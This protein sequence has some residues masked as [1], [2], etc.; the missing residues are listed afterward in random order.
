MDIRNHRKR[1]R[2]EFLNGCTPIQALI[3]DLPEEE[4]RIFNYEYTQDN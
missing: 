1:K 2:T 4:G 3:Y